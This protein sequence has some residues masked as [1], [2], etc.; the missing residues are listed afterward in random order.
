MQIL[1]DRIDR[2]YQ[3]ELTYRQANR[4]SKHELRYAYRELICFLK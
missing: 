2:F 3:L 1:F 4:V